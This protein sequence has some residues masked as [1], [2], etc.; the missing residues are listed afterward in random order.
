[1][2]SLDQARGEQVLRA[3]GEQLDAANE[4]FE[5]VVIG[6]SGLL[7]L[8]LIERATRDVDIVAL[9]REGELVDPRPLPPALVEARDRVGRDF[10]LASDWLNAAPSSLLDFGLPAG[11]A[12]RL[13]RRDYGPALTVWLASRLDQI[14]LK[15][16]ALADQ[17]PGKHEADLRALEPTRDELIEARVGRSRTTHRRVSEP[18]YSVRLR[19]SVSRMQISTLRD[20]LSDRL[21]AFAWDEWAQ[22]GVL[23]T[24][25]RE[26]PWAADPEALLLFTLEIG[27]SDP[28][29]FDEVLDWLAR[30][31]TLV[32]VQRFRNHYSDPI[33]ERLGEAAL[34]WI[35]NHGASIRVQPRQV[36]KTEAHTGLFYRGRKPSAP[37]PSFLAYG[38]LKARTKRSEK[39]QPP[40]TTKPINFAF[41]LRNGF[42]VGSRAE[43][44]RFLLTAS[45]R[46]PLGSRPL[47]TTLAIAE[48]AGYAKR[49]VHE[50]L[51]AL[52][53]AGWIELV[54]RGNERVYGVERERW[55]NGLWIEA[56][57]YPSYRDWTR[58]LQGVTELHRWLHNPATA[59]LTPYMRAS[60]ARRLM[61]QLESSFAY[62][63]I[64]LSQRQ[65]EGTAY[66][67]VFVDAVEEILSALESGLP[68]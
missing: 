6:G 54:I 26:S 9:L 16:Y 7:A 44:M 53:A 23:V 45:A 48:A 33:D 56:R 62:A 3:L 30:N 43:I 34:A 64:P 2:A 15:L 59:T 28:R 17:G 27:R 65:A 29:L 66:W 10:G 24:P 21:A 57:D 20:N 8:G 51:N 13:E 68:Q 39:S 4:Q 38:F 47:F 12:S 46:S 40:D 18:S 41:R 50:A 32:S 49:N 19:T 31:A 14:H 35:S 22:M 37:D 60:E 67:D 11:F 42:G 25:H 36:K 63:G 58:A 5:L 1:M 52:V 55:H 61:A